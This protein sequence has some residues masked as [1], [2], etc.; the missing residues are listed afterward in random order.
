MHPGHWGQSGADGEADGLDEADVRDANVLRLHRLDL[1][2][3]LQRAAKS[4]AG[5]VKDR[6][7]QELSTKVG[8][9]LA[10]HGP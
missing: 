3:V 10:C 2:H 7:K 1:L 5:L 4:L 6:G 9:S 8:L